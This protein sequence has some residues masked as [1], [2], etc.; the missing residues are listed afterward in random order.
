MRKEILINGM[1]CGHCVKRVE[2]ALDE[3]TGVKGV[4]VILEENKAII[5]LSQDIE[6][7]VIWDAIDEAGYDVEAIHTI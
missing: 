3:L 4:T 5:E 6:D 2:E 1:S 7:A